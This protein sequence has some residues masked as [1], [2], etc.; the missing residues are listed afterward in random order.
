MAAD[1]V[2]LLVGVYDHCS[3]VP[4]DEGP[5]ATLDELVAGEPRLV[6]GG[7]GVDVGGPGW[8]GVAD[9]EFAGPLHE[10]RQHESGAA[11][12]GP[13]DDGVERVHPLLGLPRITVRELVGEAV[14]HPLIMPVFKPFEW[15]HGKVPCG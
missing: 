9:V 1:A 2:G 8:R 4:P 14:D 13:I 6:H 11:A 5:D 7:D 10:L 3:G 12:S 15:A